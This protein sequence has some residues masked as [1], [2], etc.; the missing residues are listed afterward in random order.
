MKTGQRGVK[1]SMKRTRSRR[2]SASA[3]DC[4]ATAMRLAPILHHI[5][6][7]ASVARVQYKLPYSLS[8]KDL[9]GWNGSARAYMRC[10][11]YY[12]ANAL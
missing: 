11:F 5:D 10:N 4:Y 7:R 2:E 1:F 9:N 3:C 8:T 12:M 6:A